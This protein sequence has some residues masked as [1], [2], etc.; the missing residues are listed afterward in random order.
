MFKDND[1]ILTFA[2]LRASYAEVGNP[3]PAYQIQAR[4]VS[5]TSTG[6]G[7]LFD[8]FGDNPALKP[9]TV[10]SYEVGGDFSFYKGLI[11]VDLAW[12][13]KSIVDQLS[14]IHI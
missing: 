13:S 4:L 9:E 2:K 14:L 7:F 5:Q 8:F 10:S 11:N 12:F 3:A 6:G 1:R